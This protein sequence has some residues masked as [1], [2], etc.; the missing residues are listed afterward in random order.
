MQGL[1][2]STTVPSGLPINFQNLLK[3]R[4]KDQLGGQPGDDNP[5]Q[6]PQANPGPAPELNPDPVTSTQTPNMS[7]P[8]AAPEPRFVSNSNPDIDKA[9]Q[10]ALQIAG[11]QTNAAT[12]INKPVSTGRKI[13]G[14][15]AG[16]GTG[17]MAGFNP[18]AGYGMYNLVTQ[19]PAR[20]AAQKAQVQSGP[21][22]AEYSAFKDISGMDA[23]M[24]ERQA[25]QASAAA[26]G[27]QATNVSNENALKTKT[28]DFSVNHPKM[29]E[30]KEVGGN[31][32]QTPEQ[33][34]AAP[35]RN[36]GPAKPPN[37]EYKTDRN[38]NLYHAVENVA[39]I[40]KDEQGKPVQ[41]APEDLKDFNEYMSAWKM[42]H[43]NP[44]PGEID[45]AIIEFNR[46]KAVNF[47]AENIP[48][49]EKTKQDHA[50]HVSEIVSR[51]QGELAKNPKLA[52]DP[53]AYK[54]ETEAWLTKV[55]AGA[56]S[57]RPFIDEAR[58]QLL[59]STPTR[60]PAN[61]GLVDP[62]SLIP[63]Q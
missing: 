9:R 14:I 20:A 31:M 11:I 44:R 17:L 51:V 7:N 24:M 1:Q 13:A 21:L 49:A 16:I 59:R 50:A 37:G 25:Q 18:W 58:Q 48:L 3:Q 23:T 39:T 45:A 5:P 40:V 36:L 46:S 34:G 22:Q 6:D 52:T 19:A 57:W 61:N 62:N 56:P 28:F 29:Q 33:Y 30:P 55:T 15:A 35:D 26:A 42:D 60:P 2:D 41:M 4:Q 47:G 8:V 43:P 27:Q 10:L 12:E 63:K 53:D 54:R 38:G 32:V